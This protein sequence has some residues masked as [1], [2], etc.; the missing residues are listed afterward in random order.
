MEYGNIQ[1]AIRPLGMAASAALLPSSRHRG[2]TLRLAERAAPLVTHLLCAPQL[3]S[4]YKR[5]GIAAPAGPR[6]RQRRRE[7]APVEAQRERDRDEQPR[8]AAGRAGRKRAKA[9]HRALQ[10]AQVHQAAHH[11]RRVAR[12]GV[13]RR[14]VE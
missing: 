7:R 13:L 11:A 2:R 8:L 4:L 5:D 12:R 14:R 9:V 6:G 1:A 10:L 3:S